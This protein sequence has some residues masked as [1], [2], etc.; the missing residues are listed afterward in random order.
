MKDSFKPVTRKNDIVVQELK[1]ETLIYDLKSNKAYCLNE[2]SA[3]VWQLCDGKRSA[4]EISNEM[5]KRLKTLIDEDFVAIALDQLNKDGLL[6]DATELDNQFAGLSRREVIR[7]VGFASVVALPLVSSLVAPKAAMA[8]SMAGGALLAPCTGTGQGTCNTGLSCRP[9]GNFGATTG[10]NPTGISQCCT[11]VSGTNPSAVPPSIFC[12]SPSFPCSTST[13]C[14]AG[15]AMD[16]PTP[17]S[18]C[19]TNFTCTC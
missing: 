4:S 10:S 7:K 18:G 12:S 17:D 1:D 8:Q 2:T 5:S 9:T 15:T 16:A 6:E 13:L 3:L 11:P 19:G 14:C